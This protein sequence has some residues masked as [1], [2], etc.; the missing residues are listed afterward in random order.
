MRLF[1][2]SL[3]CYAERML[4]KKAENYLVLIRDGKI[5]QHKCCWEILTGFCYVLGKK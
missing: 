2:D 5:S 4:V 1:M 3:N